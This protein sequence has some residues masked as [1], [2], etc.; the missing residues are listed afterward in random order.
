[1]FNPNL[2]RER[3]E[4]YLGS[5][6][7]ETALL[8][9]AEQLT[10]STRAAPWRLDVTVNGEP[11]SYVLW[12]DSRDGVHEYEMFKA[13]QA[14]PIPT[15]RAYGWDPD[16]KALGVASY[17]CDYIAGEPLLE[18]VLKGEAWAEELFIESVTAL[19]SLSL[20]QLNP[21]AHRLAENET[22]LEV[23]ETARSCF[24]E[25]PHPICDHVHTRL[26][27]TMPVFP[28]SRFSNGDLWLENFIVKDRRLVGIIDFENAGFSDP[29]FEFLLSFFVRLELRGR[30]I[31]ARYC[32]RMG[33]D[34]QVLPW[35]HGLEYYDTLHWVLKLNKPF[36][37]HTPESLTGDLERWLKENG[38]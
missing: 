6:L 18:P 14:T 34:P 38:G 3:C 2:E 11:R 20:E 22:A 21:V 30:G 5:A 9:H 28:A 19:Q 13:M 7:K 32:K 37:G 29:I 17:F 27:E 8:T 26:V 15:P 10:Q 16:G 35:Y 31:E 36:E 33:Y 4:A 23:L 25:H 1:L 12:L 24:T